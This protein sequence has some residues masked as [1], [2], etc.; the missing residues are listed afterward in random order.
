MSKQNLDTQIVMEPVLLDR[1][2]A[3][4]ALGDMSVWKLEQL[5]KSGRIKA[6]VLDG[7]VVFEP[8]EL[9]RF[10]AECPEWE[11]AR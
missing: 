10:A 1:E 11:P 3:A 9:A 5:Y 8:A 6:R 7:S 4:A 2:A